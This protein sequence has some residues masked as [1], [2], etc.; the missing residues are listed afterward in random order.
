MIDLYFRDLTPQAQA[1]FLAANGLRNAAEGNY[2]V[3]P[4]ATLPGDESDVELSDEHLERLD[5]ID[6]AVYHCILTLLGKSEEEFPW[7][8]EYIGNV[9]DGI[10]DVLVKKGHA[11]Y[12]PAIVTEADGRQYIS[13]YAKYAMELLSAKTSDIL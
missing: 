3:L 8:M 9:T 7:S 10:V 6:N 5:E 11:I 13:E 12:R 1:R 2:D 4:I